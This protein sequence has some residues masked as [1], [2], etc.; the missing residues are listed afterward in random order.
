M[1]S[2]LK[3]K[4]YIY[5]MFGNRTVTDLR[6]EAETSFEEGMFVEEAHITTW[7]AQGISGKNIV[8]Y[9]WELPNMG[10]R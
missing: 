9:E 6:A 10:N 2:E 5:D 3:F 8:R 7:K 4:Y 1:D